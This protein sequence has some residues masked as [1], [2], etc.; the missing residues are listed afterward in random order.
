MYGLGYPHRRIAIPFGSSR[1]SSGS[2]GLPFTLLW[3]AGV[4][5][6]LNLIDGLDGL[7]GGV[8]LIAVVTS[9]ASS[10]SRREPLMVLFTA[11]LG[12]AVLGF[13]FYNFNPASIF[14]GDTGSMFLGFVLATT[15]IPHEPEVLHGG[16]DRSS[17]S[18][19]SAS[20]SPTRSSPWPAG[21]RAAL[22]LFSADRGHIHHRLLARGL[23]HRQ[24]VLVLYLAS[25]QRSARRPSR[26]RAPA[27]CRPPGA[28]S[29]SPLTAG[30]VLWRLGFVDPS[31]TEQVFEDRRRNLATL[32][33]VHRVG[34]TL[35]MAWTREEVWG[36]VRSVAEALGASAAALRL[37]ADED[38]GEDFSSG[39]DDAE[40]E[41]FVARFGVGDERTRTGDVVELGWAG[42]AMAA[43]ERGHGGR[44]GREGEEG[45]GDDDGELSLMCL[46]AGEAKWW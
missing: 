21:R 43:M 3:I 14:M 44:Q 9:F 16:R 15:A 41:L 22:P 37:A 30:L 38:E 34:E 10:R 40:R 19:R 2:S 5:N 45:K 23:T 13:L 4:I 20:P 46:V 6:A 33:V 42:S 18:S 35:R 1:S 26:S 11:A 8:A 12:G 29:A 39:F 17:P 24:T 31:K 27:R 36:A 32:S 25:R 7:A 28:C